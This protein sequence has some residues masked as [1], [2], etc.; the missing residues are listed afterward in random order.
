V[1]VA[2]PD[3]AISALIRGCE[4][5]LAASRITR[6]WHH[7]LLSACRGTRCKS[8]SNEKGLQSPTGSPLAHV[9]DTD[10]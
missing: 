1:M 2:T 5:H 9:F 6:K 7:H 3:N 10:L 8:C 4:P